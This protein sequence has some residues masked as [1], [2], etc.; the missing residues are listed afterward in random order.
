MS[1]LTDP[2]RIQYNRYGGPEQ[3]K[4]ERF[5]PPEPR[6]GEVLV[7]VRAAAANALDWKIRNG[8][9]K[10][11]SGRGFP[12]GLGHDFAG[13]V[14]QVG[15][16]VTRFGAGDEVFGS[17]GMKASGA[18][19]EVVVADIKFIAKKPV[20]VSFE[21]AAALPIAGVTALQ[22]ITDRGRLKAGQSMFING[23]LGGVGRIA[24]QMALTRGIKV[25]GSCR[26][27]ARDDAEALGISPIVGFNFEAAE[28]KERFD[29]VFDT[30][31]TLSRTTARTLM[32]PDGDITDIVGTPGK[33]LR[34]VLPGPYRMQFTKPTTQD[35]ETVVQA[36]AC[37]RI[38]L[39]IARTVALDDAIEALTE[40]ETKSTPK[41]GKLVVI[42]RW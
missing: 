6:K 2:R 12:R 20:E 4:L 9:L 18:F 37:D 14:E 35:L 39:R 22:A 17:V 19:G 3:M 10:M 29:L 21:Q 27:S 31:G 13:V 42:N 7:R 8:E 33:M 38:E 23:C 11:L 34:S 40:L 25:A 30:A 32:K 28:L 16:G 24:A 1:Q 41:G 5:T 36:V 15:D 26:D